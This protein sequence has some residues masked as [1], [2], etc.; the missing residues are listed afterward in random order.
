MNSI[1]TQAFLSQCNYDNFVIMFIFD[2]WLSYA[3]QFLSLTVEKPY[4]LL[5]ETILGEIYV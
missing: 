5:D 1:S 3:R 2:T 4:L